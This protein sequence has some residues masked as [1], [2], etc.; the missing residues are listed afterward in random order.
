MMTCLG[1]NNHQSPLISGFDTLLE[2]ETLIDCTVAAE[3]KFLKAY[4]VVLLAFSPNFA[5]LLQD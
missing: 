2:N 5:T 4:K 1:W 3:G